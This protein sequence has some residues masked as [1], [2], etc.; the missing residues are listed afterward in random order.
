MTVARSSSGGVAIPGR[1]LMSMS[2]LLLRPGRFAEYCD[3]PVS[4]CVCLSVSVCA[5]LSANISLE[6]LDR[7]SRK[8]CADPLWPWLDPHLTALRY[9]MYFRFYG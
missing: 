4:L 7:S 1:S 5:C 9:V 3:Q 8:F 6:P 2:A